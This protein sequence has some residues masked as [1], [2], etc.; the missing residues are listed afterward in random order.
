M[1]KYQ[2]TSS[3]RLGPSNRVADVTILD[4][5]H[6]SGKEAH[7]NVTVSNFSNILVTGAISNVVLLPI[8]R[9][10]LIS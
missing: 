3:T 9:H 4:T 8:E 10:K 2:T 6:A 7:D 1:V 5:A